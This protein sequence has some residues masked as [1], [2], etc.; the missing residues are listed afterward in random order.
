MKELNEQFMNS[1]FSGHVSNLHDYLGAHIIYDK[2]GLI[3]GT[4]FRVYA[5]NAKE[6]RLASEMND[7]QGW[8]TVLNKVSHHGFFEITIP[9]NHEWKMYKYEINTNSGEV[10]YKSDPFGYFAEERPGTASKVYDINHFSWHDEVWHYTKKKSYQEPLLIY[11]VHL[12][13]WRRKYG[14]F[15]P[16]N[17]VVHELIEYVLDQ[18]FTHI[19]LL[20]IYEYPL[21]DSW[22]YQGTGYFAATSRYGSPKDLMYLIDECHQAGLGII[23]DWVLGHICKDSHGL[24]FFDGSPLFEFED[25]HRRENIVWGTNNLDFSK[26]ITRSFMLSAL[27]FWMDYYHVDGF[28]IDAVSNLIFYLGN[29][30]EGVNQ[31]AIDFIRQLSTHLFSKDDRILFMAEDS[32]AYPKVTHPV[33]QGGIGF[34]YKWNMGFMNDV[35][36]YF[37]EDPIYRKFHHDK[38]TFGLVYAFSE[39]YVLPFSHD[40]VVHL[41]GSLVNKMPGDYEQKIANWKLLLTLWMTHPGKK[42]LFMGQEFAQFSEWAFQGELDWFLY[43][44]EIHQKANHFFKDLVQVYKHHPALYQYDHE[45]KGFKWSVTDDADQSV[46]AYVRKSDNETLIIILNMTPNVH[47]TYEIGVPYA[48]RYEEILNSDKALYNGSDQYNGK[49]LH[50]IKGDKQGFKYFVK[51]K[52]GPFAGIVLLHKK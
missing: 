46:F 11:E 15:K 9:G 37:K 30:D 31:D 50:A 5:P 1:F 45:A 14:A 13:S 20:P 10:L 36:R 48:G 51:P 38:I 7:Y 29:S 41:K 21:D 34:N 3:T 8:I 33:D 32:T 28:R 2:Q 25:Q 16:Y 26:G 4:R 18:G 24:S 52:V 22:G 19:E 6:V 12:G 43:D 49:Q 35:L 27:T 42:L 17:E 23:I 40:E 39:Q 44:N 47:E